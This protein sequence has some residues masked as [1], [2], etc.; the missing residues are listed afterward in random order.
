MPNIDYTG[1]TKKEKEK[2]EKDNLPEKKKIEAVVVTPVIVQRK[3][4]GRKFRDMMVAAKFKDVARYIGVEVLKPAAQAMIFDSLTKG[5]ERVIYP[6]RTQIRRPISG[7]PRI[8]YTSYNNPIN[9]DRIRYGPVATAPRTTARARTEDLILATREEAELVLER[10]Q[11]IIDTYEVV[12]VA[13]LNELVGLQASHVDNKWGWTY[14]GD[15]QIRAI[16]E[17]YLLDLP[18]AEAIP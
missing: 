4:L 12:S 10:M 7:S 1:N 15:V 17:G 8:T 11:D 14:V 13:D 18:P 6:D 16:R 3:S 5:S 9:R 2:K